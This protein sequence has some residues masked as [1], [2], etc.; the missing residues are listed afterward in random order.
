M[1][2]NLYEYI[3]YSNLPVNQDLSITLPEV[4][5]DDLIFEDNLFGSSVV[6]PKYVNGQDYD[7][8]YSMT[9]DLVNYNNK[10]YFH[11][12]I[13]NEIGVFQNCIYTLEFDMLGKECEVLVNYYDKYYSD[14]PLDTQV[15]NNS[16]FTLYKQWNKVIQQFTIPDGATSM[17][18]IFSGKNCIYNNLSVKQGCPQVIKDEAPIWFVSRLGKKFLT[19][20]QD[21]DIQYEPPKKI[22]KDLRDSGLINQSLK[23]FYLFAL[24]LLEL[25]ALAYYQDNNQEAFDCLIPSDFTRIQHNINVLKKILIKDGDNASFLLRVDDLLR[26]LGYMRTAF[27]QSTTSIPETFGG[28]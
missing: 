13:S 26:D 8:K 11:N 14:E 9:A 20:M 1:K 27:Y 17:E 15:L 18:I 4:V 7:D 10:K 12:V 23:T 16:S 6:N 25:R 22:V 19:D 3:L 21:F 24:C 28:R 2:L 5:R